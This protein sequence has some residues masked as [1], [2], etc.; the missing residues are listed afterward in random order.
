VWVTFGLLVARVVHAAS[1]ALTI[2][3]LLA[4]TFLLPGQDIARGRPS[5]SQW[6]AV[7]IAR[8]SASV[9]LAAAIAGLVFTAANTIGAPI[10]AP[11]FGRT[12][13]YFATE[14][15]LGQT[16]LFSIGCIVVILHILLLSRSVPWIAAAAAIAVFAL[17][18]LSLSG[19]AAGSDEHANAVNS[20]AIHL[21][22]VT[23]WA[24]GLA[25]V[26][27][28]RRKAGPEIGRVVARYSVL[29]G[30]AFGAVA[31]SGIINASL[32]LSGPS[33]LLTPYGSLVVV[34]ASALVVLGLAGAWHRRR[35]IPRLEAEPE[36]RGPFIRL[37]VGEIVVMAVAMGARSRCRGAN[38]PSP[39]SR[40]S[41]TS[42]TD[43][44]VSSI[45]LPCR[46]CG[47]SRSGTSTG[48]G[49]PRPS[50]EP[51]CT[52]GRST[53][54]AR[55]ATRGQGGGRSRGSRAAPPCCGRPRAARPSTARS[56]SAP[57]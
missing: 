18:P 35:L 5:F 24:G 52:S 21:I 4:A 55:E 39:K 37:A 29:A 53:G 45:R 9:W 27:I 56:T 16:L 7:R 8:W 23:A 17:L 13:V 33:D 40:S 50:W 10:D 42:V 43:S 15:E 54:S 20:L 44:S 26:V 46:R 12:F 49:P 30:W 22:G 2:G 51:C 57:T 41:A 48:C 36:R 31:F 19:H 11:V 47:C 28:L 1:A 32:R 3:A 6:W 14:L 25:A 34:K 38:R